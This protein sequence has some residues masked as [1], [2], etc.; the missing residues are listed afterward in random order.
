MRVV[1]LSQ[2][3]ISLTRKKQYKLVKVTREGLAN[4]NNRAVKWITYIDHHFEKENLN[5]EICTSCVY[6]DKYYVWIIQQT[7]KMKIS[8]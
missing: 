7:T 1:T 8:N 6:N 2:G 4:F 5:C 3:T